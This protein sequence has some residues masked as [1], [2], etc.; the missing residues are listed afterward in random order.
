[1]DNCVCHSKSRLISH[2]GSMVFVPCDVSSMINCYMNGYSFLCLY[3][4]ISS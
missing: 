4:E 3:L 1:M 2:Y